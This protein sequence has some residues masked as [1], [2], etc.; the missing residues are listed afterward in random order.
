[1]AG[2]WAWTWKRRCA[3]RLPPKFEERKNFMAEVIDDLRLKDFDLY[4][5]PY[6]FSSIKNRHQP[7]TP[8]FHFS[9]TSQFYKK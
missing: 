8:S 5:G 3:T 9:T 1:M 6:P 4:T 2:H 7:A